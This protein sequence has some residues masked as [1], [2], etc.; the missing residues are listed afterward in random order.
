[1]LVGI[2]G[3]PNKGKSTLFS[4][5]TMSE[6][7]IANYPFTTIDPNLGIAY[8]TKECA[9]RSLNVKCMPRNSLCKDGIRELPVNMIDVAGLV[10]G[11]HEGKGMGNQF[12]ND[13]AA[14]DALLIVVDASG[15]TDPNGNSCENS[16]PSGD[17]KIVMNELTEWLFS[18]LKR[19]MNVVSKSADGVD[20]LLQVLAGLKVTRE[21]IEKA[22]S[23][24]YLPTT[25][26]NWPDGDIRAFA[27]ALLKNTKPALIVANKSDA[28]GSEGSIDALKKEFGDDNVIGCSAAIELAL[29][30]ADAQ[31]L[32]EYT[33]GARDFKIMK[34]STKEQGYA[35]EYMLQFLKGKGTNVQEILNRV[36]FKLLDNI[37]VYPVE[38]ENRYTD[39][40]G[41][42]LPDAILVKRGSTTLDLAGKIHTDLA[43]NMLY[44]IDARSKRRL[45]KDYV[46]SDGDVIKIVSAAR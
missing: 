37:V 8:V 30:K 5:I 20:G 29:R 14:S 9:E 11:A 32:I 10:E 24:A 27:V 13:L 35:L 2:I 3:A 6:V 22:A 25:S 12:L 44:A 15:K 36:V 17:V 34:E 4:A 45:G 43:K 38:D 16:D 41:N 7:A 39:H 31:K 18:I 28:K 42:V 23:Q 33:P 46:L 1:M 40:F 19:H 21:D 26:I